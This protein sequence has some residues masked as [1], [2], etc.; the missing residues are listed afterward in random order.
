MSCGTF[1]SVLRGREGAVFC[2]VVWAKDWVAKRRVKNTPK[3][4][5]AIFSMADNFS[6]GKK[7]MKSKLF[8]AI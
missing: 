4:I 6:M 1:A 2:G 3:I 5:P 7:R 8:E